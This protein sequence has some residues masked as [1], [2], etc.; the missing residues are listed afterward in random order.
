M[1]EQISARS[2]KKVSL[3]TGLTEGELAEIAK[4]CREKLYQAGECCLTIGEKTEAVHIVQKGRVGVETQIPDAPTGRKDVILAALGPGED[5]SW[6]ALLGK[7]PTASVRAIELSNV[8]S[9]DADT[10][11]ALCE[12]KNRI[13]YVVMKN[14]AS[15]ISSRLK[16]HR[17]ALLSA[18]SGI[19]D[20]W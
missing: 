14:L 8:L 10:L 13:G 20:G 12:N 2:L 19:G 4:L 16:R 1:S 17:L 11:I 5:F 9:I 18:V 15:I 7:I 3:F 6:S